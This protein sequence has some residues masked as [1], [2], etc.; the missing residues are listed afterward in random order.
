MG[1]II[2]I[3]FN[4]DRTYLTVVNNTP[5]GLSLDY[6]NSTNHRVD[7][8]NFNSEES[9]L[10]ITELYKIFNEINMELSILTVTLS[11]ETIPVTQFPGTPDLSKSDLLELA[12]FELKQIYP[13]F[14]FTD[15]SVS[16]VPFEPR[17]NGSMSYFASFMPKENHDIIEQILA[18]LNLPIKNI[19]V[20]Q[21][22]AHSA[23]LYNYPEMAD[24]VVAILGYQGQFLDLSVLKNGKPIYYN[25]SSL[26]N[27]NDIPDIIDKE[28][29]KLIADYVDQV[30]AAYYFGNALNKVNSIMMWESCSL[31]MVM[32]AKRLNAFRMMKSSLDQR[33]KDYCSRVFH[34][35]PPCIGGCMPS[36]HEVIKF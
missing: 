21:F 14:N 7:I 30:D 9:N 29:N 12:E 16:I 25:L 35:Y 10:G 28:Y 20:S 17:K 3:Y 34:L 31:M 2:S 19:E 22:N 24:K 4:I 18:P 5:S 36:K 23:F 1:R 26:S 27:E 32:E 11:S 33:Q 15:F 6:V 13:H 8:E